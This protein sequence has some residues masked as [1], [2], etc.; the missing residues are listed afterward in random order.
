MSLLS[1]LFKPFMT[2]WYRTNER[3]NE[4]AKGERDSVKT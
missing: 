2:Y 4:L 3:T 1:K